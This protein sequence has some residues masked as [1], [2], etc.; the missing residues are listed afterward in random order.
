MSSQNASDKI[1]LPYAEALLE[2][3]NENKLIDDIHQS[4]STVRDLLSE[5]TDLQ[6]FLNNPLMSVEIKKMVISKL[7][8]SQINTFLLKFLFVLVD[9]R[10]INVLNS[11]IDKYFDLAYKLDS[12]I[13]ASVSTSVAL[14]EVQQEAIVNKLKTMTNSKQIKLD[15][16]I[17][18][19]LIGG[20]T[21]QVGSKV[22]DT[23]LAGKLKNMAFYLSNT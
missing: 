18:T 10:R 16:N 14:N 23:S 21:I 7:L 22:I 8:S 11:I 2:Y 6:V 5:S 15:M 1:A 4:L 17:D 9:R 3:A 12:T 20:F 13:I 19:S